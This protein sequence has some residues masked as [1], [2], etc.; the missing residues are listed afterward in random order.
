[1]RHWPHPGGCEN[2]GRRAPT[3]Q[4]VIEAFTSVWEDRP[5]CS[6]PETGGLSIALA[7]AHQNAQIPK[8]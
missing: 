6:R 8:C 4:E 2:P 3:T 1:M 7:K 5:L